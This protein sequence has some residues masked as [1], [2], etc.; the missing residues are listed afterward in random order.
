MDKNGKLKISWNVHIYIK[1]RKADKIKNMFYEI[2]KKSVRN[3]N[4]YI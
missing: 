2:F 1:N 3:L 4:Y